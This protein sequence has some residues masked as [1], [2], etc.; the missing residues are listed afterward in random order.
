MAITMNQPS[1]ES[2]I[3]TAIRQ[4]LPDRSVQ[5]DAGAE[6][7]Q[8]KD[9]AA[10]SQNPDGT[11]NFSFYGLSWFE[12]KETPFTFQD[13]DRLAEAF[14]TKQINWTKDTRSTGYCESCYDV[15][16]T[17]VIEVKGATVP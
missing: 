5:V 17:T 10:P 14:K 13:A 4:T 7:G 16:E 12:E 6:Y 2:R 3:E 9:G 11:W 15:W 8:D 1:I